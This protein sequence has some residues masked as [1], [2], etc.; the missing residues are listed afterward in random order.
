M[1][2]L[3]FTSV[4]RSICPVC[5][6]TLTVVCMS[7]LWLSFWLHFLVRFSTHV[8]L[9]NRLSLILSRSSQEPAKG[10]GWQCPYLAVR[11]QPPSLELPRRLYPL[12]LPV[13]LPPSVQLLKNGRIDIHKG[14]SKKMN[15]NASPVCIW[16]EK[17]LH[18]LYWQVS[19][20]R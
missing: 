1:L 13:P 6:H 18:L 17:S 11:R 3:E 14:R 4:Q 12:S 7:K 19:S 10:W 15:I 20:Q 2:S 9:M 16:W 5:L 8:S